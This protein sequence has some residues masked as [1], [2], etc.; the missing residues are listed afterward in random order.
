[1]FKCLVTF[2]PVF[3]A[4]SSDTKAIQ[5]DDL[6]QLWRMLYYNPDL[7]VTVMDEVHQS[8]LTLSR[9]KGRFACATLLLMYGASVDRPDARRRGKYIIKT[10]CYSWGLRSCHFY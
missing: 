10:C 5:N 6:Y 8:P 3:E 7:A 4:A 1:M 9:S 2:L